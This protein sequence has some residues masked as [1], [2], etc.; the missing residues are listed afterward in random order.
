MSEASVATSA[1][2][3]SVP[4]APA[5]LSPAQVE[6][7]AEATALAKAESPAASAF[8]L[9]LLAGTFIGIGATFMLVVKAD[10]TLPFAASTLLGAFAFVAGLFL[11][12]AAGAELFTGDCLMVMGP[13]AGKVS[14]GR[15]AGRLAL[16][17]VGN[18][19]GS[20]AMA[21]LVLGA[22]V[23]Q[24]NG[25]AFGDAAVAVATAKTSMGWGTIFFRGILCNMLVCLAVWIGYSATSVA[26]RLVA[27][28]LPIMA[29][30]AAGFEHCVA[31]MFFL[32]YALMLEGSG[33]ASGSVGM[34]G[35]AYNLS[36]ATLGNMVG[37][38]VL[39]GIAYWFAYGRSAS[40]KASNKAPE[41]A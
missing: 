23:A 41:K 8:V 32:P 37:G 15:V 6:R 9:A 17:Y 26:D 5:L 13:L 38:M 22:G 16:V 4:Q 40:I 27:A 33:I 24:L 35:F 28:L 2:S 21:A 10:S 25:G 14:W 19:L 30:I 7:K 31:N 29:F 36:A 39:V 1:A 34:G 18:L 11:V 20:L 3:P 12:L